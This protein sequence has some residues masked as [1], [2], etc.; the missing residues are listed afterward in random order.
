MRRRAV[1]HDRC[2]RQSAVTVALLYGGK[3]G[4]AG[5]TSRAHVYDNREGPVAGEA[6]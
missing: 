6:K 2:L 1:E 4:F 5:T 3:V